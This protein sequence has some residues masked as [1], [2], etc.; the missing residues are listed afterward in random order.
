[1]N[2]VRG[3]PVSEKLY[4]V[5]WLSNKHWFIAYWLPPL[6]QTAN[7]ARQMT[8]HQLSITVLVSVNIYCVY[9]HTHTQ[10]SVGDHYRLRVKNTGSRKSGLRFK[11]H[12]LGTSFTS[13]GHITHYIKPQPPIYYL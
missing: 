3:L 6:L 8:Q 7:S 12:P 13:L 4:S 10:R 2:K 9:T 5:H 1:M 11:S